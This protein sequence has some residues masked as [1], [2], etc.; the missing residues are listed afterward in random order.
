MRDF[1]LDEIDD[2][3]GL[4]IVLETY[5]AR[6]A[7]ERAEA[8]DL[9]RLD[10]QL[11]DLRRLAARGEVAALVEADLRFHLSICEISGNRK[12]LGMFSDLTGEVRMIIALIGQLF[13]DPER[14]AET[15]APILEALAAR[16]ADRLEAE[17][18]HHIRVAWRE[19]RRI[20][21]DRAPAG[22][23]A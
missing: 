17:V 7:C 11:E 6:L 12:L 1:Q 5:A 21:A 15:H 10:R 3:Y 4:R 14:I 8:G 9:A 19:V 23:E 22:G 20:F 18:D 16:D 2:I 13:D